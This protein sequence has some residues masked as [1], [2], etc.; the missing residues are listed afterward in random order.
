MNRNQQ[1]KVLTE[2]FWTAKPRRPV[3]WEV[4]R[5]SPAEGGPIDRKNAFAPRETSDSKESNSSPSES[6][7]FVWKIAA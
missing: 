2:G 6:D 7:S 5:I 4:K 1:L 3:I